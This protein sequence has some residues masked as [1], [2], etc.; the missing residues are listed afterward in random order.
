MGL[1]LPTH[2]LWRYM[3]GDVSTNV[4]NFISCAKDMGFLHILETTLQG[5]GKVSRSMEL[6]SRN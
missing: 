4:M 3:E 5:S 6:C 2:T 1:N